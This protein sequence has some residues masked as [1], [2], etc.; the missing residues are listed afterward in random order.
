MVRAARLV[1]SPAPGRCR[2]TATVQRTQPDR[3]HR[4]SI[5]RRPGARVCRKSRRYCAAARLPGPAHI[6]RRNAG[7]LAGPI[8]HARGT[9]GWLGAGRRPDLVLR[10]R[11]DAVD[12]P[13]SQCR[14]RPVP[15]SAARRHWRAGAGAPVIEKEFPFGRVSRAL[16]QHRLSAGVTGDGRSGSGCRVLRGSGTCADHGR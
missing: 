10:R 5:G 7:Y 1:S 16:V 11:S 3:F 8:P 6:D 13:V 12:L 14:S 15:G 4:N 2:V 9:D